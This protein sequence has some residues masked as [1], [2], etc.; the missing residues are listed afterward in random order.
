VQLTTPSG[1][2]LLVVD[3][4]ALHGLVGECVSSTS[5]HLHSMAGPSLLVIVQRLLAT[6]LAHYA[7]W[8]NTGRAGS[9]PNFP[10]VPSGS[11]RVARA[12]WVSA[13]EMS[14]S[15][16]SASEEKRWRSELRRAGPRRYSPLYFGTATAGCT[17]AAA[18]CGLLRRDDG[19]YFALLTL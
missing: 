10:A 4:K 18:H 1:K 12:R 17:R 11:E 8:V 2:P 3:R 19:R 6:W 5:T 14:L 15:V 16:L 7:R 9:K 13:L